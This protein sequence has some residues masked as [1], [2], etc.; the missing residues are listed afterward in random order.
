MSVL[1]VSDHESSVNRVGERPR[2]RVLVVDDE[3]PI[4]KFLERVLNEAGYEVTTASTGAE[5]LGQ[6]ADDSR[7]DLI[8]TDLMMPGM[9]GDELV[10]HLRRREPNLKI[11][12]LTGFADSLFKEK[13]SLWQ[14]E[15]FLDKP[16]TANGL[17]EAVS[18]ILFE[19]LVPETPAR[20][21]LLDRLRG[22]LF[23]HQNGY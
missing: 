19:R 18:M 2:L 21:S 10:A 20:P 17:L 16:C 8:L 11:L 7:F 22:M 14:H 3:P 9:R 12:Y 5:A 4:L 23:R 1:A 15:A 6:Y 13:V